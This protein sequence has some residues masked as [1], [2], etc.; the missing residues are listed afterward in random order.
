MS[1]EFVESYYKIYFNYGILPS[2]DI[3]NRGLDSNITSNEK[4]A[5]V[6]IALESFYLK[7]GIKEYV[8]RLE[9][10]SV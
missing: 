5:L 8:E 3:L 7:V 10:C 2:P 6:R 1:P 4:R 9:K